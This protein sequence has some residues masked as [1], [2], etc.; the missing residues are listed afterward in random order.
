MKGETGWGIPVA[1]DIAF[2]LG[3]LALA[4]PRVPA[5]LKVFLLALAIVDDLGAILVIA[6]FYTDD[7][8]LEPLL[9][10]ALVLGA[11]VA[12]R[13]AGVRPVLY[14]VIPGV[15]FWMA[16]LKSG[17]HATLAGVVLALLTPAGAAMTIDQYRAALARLMERL[18]AAHAQGDIEA[19]EDAVASITELA[20]YREAPLD[21]IEHALHPWTSFLVIPLFALANAGIDLSGDFFADAATSS[22]SLGIVAGLVAGKLLGVLGACWLFIRLGIATLPAGVS[23]AQLAGAGLL[24]GIGFTVSLFI[25]D[26]AFSDE[27]LVSQAKGG[28]FA[29][30]LIAG[31]AGYALLRWQS[32]GKAPAG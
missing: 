14:Y 2:A 32:H 28:I 6:V 19:E 13:F 31:A 5:S 3:V 12:S 11:V 10:G 7:L 27:D 17:V 29:A 22:V 4:G 23:W 26:L 8:A 1:T 24:A 16:V 18:A 21:R 20:E 9:W 25:A 30:S 15:L